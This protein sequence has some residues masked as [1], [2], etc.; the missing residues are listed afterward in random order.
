[1]FENKK[2]F[3]FGM[4]KSGYEVAKLLSKYNNLILI[5]DSKEQDIDRVNE[6][7]DL[8]VD[9]VI[10]E[11]QIDL[12]D[13]SYDYMIK[14]PGIPANNPVVEKA[15]KLGIKIINE[16]ECA[17]HFLPRNVKIIGITGSNGK[18][19]T[20]TI[21]Y[22]ILK[23]QYN[24]VYLGGNIGYPLSQIVE[25]IKENS[26][27]VMEI[28]DHQLCDMYDFKTDISLL[29]NLVHAHI[30]FHGSY[31]KYKEMKK[32]IFNNHSKNDLAILNFDNEDVMNL[33]KDIRSSKKYF[34]KSKKKDAYI[35]DA[36]I[37]YNGEE[38][39]ECKDIK[40]KG[41]H[42]YEN[43][44]AA[45]I[46][47]KDLKVE[48]KIIKKFLKTF[49]GVEHRIE[50]VKTIKGVDYYNDSKSTNNEATITALKTFN[51]PTILIM[52]GLD[53]NI[54]FDELK[55]YMNNVKAIVCYGETK[56]KIKKFAN[57]NRLEC[58]VVDSLNEAV[59]R[60][61]KISE[62]GDTVLLS[63]ACASWDQFNTFEE[64]GNLFKELVNKLK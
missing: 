22:E 53:R 9:V 16:I 61:H 37:Y 45:I 46:V 30:D 26:Y 11:N 44:M 63:P 54:P 39:I 7:E 59:I 18:T 35:K 57:K 29:L 60:S 38:I 1:M 17:Y 52:G 5:T 13:D 19:T 27:L 21:I 12:I 14:N 47:L 31:D 41:I 36:T 33:T 3:I 15:K 25:Q 58:Y 64:R 49:G 4:A 50:Y 8:G 24:N 10:T 28:S 20:T 23:K 51:N 2:I 48:N 62:S 34:S 6:L 43:I 55:E 40:L 32:R 56:D 42:N